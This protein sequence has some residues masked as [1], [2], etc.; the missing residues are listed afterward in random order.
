V[1]GGDADADAN[2]ESPFST[3]FFSFPASSLTHPLPAHTTTKTGDM[4][5]SGK[6]RSF[7]PSLFSSSS[8]G[9]ADVVS[10][11]LINAGSCEA[12]AGAGP[13]RRERKD[14]AGWKGK[15]G[16]PRDV[17]RVHALS[18]LRREPHRLPQTQREGAMRAVHFY[19]SAKLGFHHPNKATFRR[20]LHWDSDT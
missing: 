1:E 19:I 17:P 14:P 12:A 15:S 16:R 8:F 3:L 7:S 5:W 13:A 20:R 10:F 9:V 6:S 18:F 2:V 4:E 11:P